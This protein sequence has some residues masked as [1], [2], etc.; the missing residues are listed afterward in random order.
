MTQDIFHGLVEIMKEVKSDA[1][2]EKGKN[3]IE[4]LGLDS[5]DVISLLFEAEKRFDIKIPEE[6]IS[7]HDLLN[8]DKFVAYIKNKMAQ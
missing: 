6:D 7:E 2:V 1:K 3:L 4:D 5:L 8:I